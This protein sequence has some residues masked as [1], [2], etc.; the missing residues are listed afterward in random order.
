MR[1]ASHLQLLILTEYVNKTHARAKKKKKSCL[2][3]FQNTPRMKRANKKHNGGAREPLP[4]GLY[5]GLMQSVHS[6]YKVK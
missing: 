5:T 1:S 3:G 2:D 4:E 6:S